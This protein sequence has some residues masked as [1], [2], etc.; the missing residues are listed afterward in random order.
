[1]DFELSVKMN[2]DKLTDSEKEMVKFMMNRPQ[3]VI[4]RNIVELGEAMLSSKSSVLRLAKK[5]GYRGFSEL[6]YVVRE[7]MTIST[8][9][10]TD[11]TQLLKQD[12]DWIFRYVDQT[13][14]QP[15]LQK[16]KDARMVFLY[17]TGFS[18]NNFA[19][20]FSKDLMI[21][22]RANMLISGESNLS[23]SSSIIMEDDL[24]IFTSFSGETAGIKDVI[25]T[26]KMKNVPIAAITK[27]GSNFLSEHADYSFYFEASPLPSYKHSQSVHSLIGLEVILDVIARKYREFILFDE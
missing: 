22:N 24:I 4:N 1:M 14:F 15:F 16:L 26:L 19:K 7:S 2:Y 12:L 11:L 23:I 17:A 25:R 8:L 27:F 9:E 13:N 18:Q 21:A 20:E 10:P 6:K 3:D 5:L